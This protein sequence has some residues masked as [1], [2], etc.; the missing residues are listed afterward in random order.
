MRMSAAAADQGEAW[1]CANT[2]RPT[3]NTSMNVPMNSFAS[4]DGKI[5]TYSPTVLGMNSSSLTRRKRRDATAA[6]TA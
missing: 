3:V 4:F 1:D 6:P 5:G 2:F